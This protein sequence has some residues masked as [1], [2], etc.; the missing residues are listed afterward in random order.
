[1]S[2]RGAARST[3]LQRCVSERAFTTSRM[4]GTSMG[5]S[6]AAPALRLGA[7]LPVHRLGYGAIHLTGPGYWGPPSDPDNAIRLL[8]RAVD[9]GVDFIGTADSY[10]PDANEQIIRRALHP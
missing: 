4:R 6:S 7:D 2:I 8:R 10:G 1:M 9:L 5:V 3:G